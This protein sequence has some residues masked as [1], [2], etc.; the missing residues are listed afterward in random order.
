MLC[1]PSVVDSR[2]LTR[3]MPCSAIIALPEC[4]LYK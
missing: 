4:D 1:V 2:Y 3:T